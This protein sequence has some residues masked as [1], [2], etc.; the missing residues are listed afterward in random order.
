[1]LIIISILLEGCLFTA[2]LSLHLVNFEFIVLLNNLLNPSVV[3]RLIK[4]Q[5]RLQTCYL[6]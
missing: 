2:E 5:F 6:I 3:L 4:L 1:M